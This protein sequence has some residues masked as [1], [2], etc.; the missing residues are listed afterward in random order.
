[1]NILETIYLLTKAQFFHVKE[2]CEIILNEDII[3]IEICITFYTMLTKCL[4]KFPKE[5]I[6]L[7]FQEINMKVKKFGYK[8]VYYYILY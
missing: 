7:F 1:M 6:I 5:C 2:I 3:N 8:K 4:L